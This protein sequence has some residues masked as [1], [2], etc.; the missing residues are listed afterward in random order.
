MEYE[1]K[2]TVRIRDQKLCVEIPMGTLIAYS[3]CDPEYPGIYIDLQREGFEEDSPLALVEYTET[4]ADLEPQGHIIS[5]I[6]GNVS[7]EDYS[8]RIVHKGF[9]MI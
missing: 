4:E 2:E 9:E 5:R 1:N 3:S 7:K 6:W 8:N